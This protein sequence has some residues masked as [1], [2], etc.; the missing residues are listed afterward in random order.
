MWSFFSR[1]PTKDFAYEI[2]EPIS[3]DSDRV[4]WKL[5]KGKKKVRDCLVCVIDVVDV[6]VLDTLFLNISQSSGEEVTIFILDTKSASVTELEAI[7]AG[8]K[9]LKTL[10]HPSILTF[11]DSV[12]VNSNSVPYS[13]FIL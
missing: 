12:E 7:R 3:Y 5:H 11:L 2:G 9:R 10:R 4:L 1:D 13:Y 6:C 8:V